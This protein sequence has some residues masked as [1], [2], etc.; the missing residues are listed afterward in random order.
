[1]LPALRERHL[2]LPPF[3]HLPR[4]AGAIRTWRSTPTLQYSITTR[5]R[6]RGRG[7]RS[8]F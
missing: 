7:R 6:I 8:A 2:R 5:G 1:M 4:Y 3:E